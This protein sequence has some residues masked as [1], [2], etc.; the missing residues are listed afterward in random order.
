M[1]RA[2]FTSL[3]AS[4]LVLKP[5]FHFVTA[6]IPIILKRVVDNTFNSKMIYW[7]IYLN[8]FQGLSSSPR[9]TRA[10]PRIPISPT[11]QVIHSNQIQASCKLSNPKDSMTQNSGSRSVSELINPR[12]GE[13]ER[14]VLKPLMSF[15]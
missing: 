3:Y 10:T 11:C 8:N 7:Y 13:P 5:R 4:W 12:G 15:F 9:I 2:R 14:A 6:Q 1:A